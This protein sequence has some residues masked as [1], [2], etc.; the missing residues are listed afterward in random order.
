[1]GYPGCGLAD[2]ESMCLRLIST[3]LGGSM[4]SRLFREIRDKR[5]L[6]YQVGSAYTPHQDHSPLI[7]YVVTTSPNR[8]QAADCTIAE[9]E[10]LKEELVSPEELRRVKTYIN[11]TYIMSL[12]T[13][14]GQATRYGVYEIAGLGW[15]YVNR[16]TQEVE[17]V[18]PEEI[19]ATARK[20]FTQR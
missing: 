8:Q 20:F 11:G 14:M 10:R 1:I 19:Q 3:I 13:N 17:Q 16:F 18:T 15:D 12:E 4:D 9:I 6:C 2:K 7:A 5:G